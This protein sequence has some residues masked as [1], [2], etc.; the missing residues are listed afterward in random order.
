MECPNCHEEIPSKRCPHC[1][2]STP[3]ESRYCMQCGAYMDEA[4]PGDE[5]GDEND[6]GDRVLCSDGTC[7]GI[8]IDGKCSECGKPLHGEPQPEVETS[9]EVP[10]GTPE[11][12]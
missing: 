4:V 11:N 9:S 12:E 10:E 7:T 6:F 1:E 2:G 5:T 8:I 3:V